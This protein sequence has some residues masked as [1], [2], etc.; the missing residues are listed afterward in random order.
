MTHNNDINEDFTTF[1]E[2]ALHIQ[3]EI[4]FWKRWHNYWIERARNKEVPVFFFR[5]EDLLANPT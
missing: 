5:F 3:E 2:W 4:G 1:P